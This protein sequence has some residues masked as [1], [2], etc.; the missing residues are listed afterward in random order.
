[1]KIANESK[2]QSLL[3]QQWI[4]IWISDHYLYW[5]FV[6]WSNRNA[7]Q[8][9]HFKCFYQASVD[10]DKAVQQLLHANFKGKQA[11][12]QRSQKTCISV[13]KKQ[14]QILKQLIDRKITNEYKNHFEKNIF[15]SCDAIAF[16]E[17]FLASHTCTQKFTAKKKTK[18]FL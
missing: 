15:R 11:I 2:F 9:K 8:S 6:L 5:W 17:N 1:M 3:T 13:S 10:V 12:E 16:F 18:L 4:A 14:H 7:L